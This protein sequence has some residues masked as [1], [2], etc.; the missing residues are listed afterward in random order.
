ML[1]T[2]GPLDHLLEVPV[3]KTATRAAPRARRKYIDEIDRRLHEEL[4]EL[5]AEYRQ[6]AA[7]N[8]V[9][10]ATLRMWLENDEPLDVPETAAMFGITTETLHDWVHE[11]YKAIAEKRPLDHKCFIKHDVRKGAKVRLWHFNRL[12]VY[13]WRNQRIR[14]GTTVATPRTPSGRHRTRGAAQAAEAA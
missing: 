12:L 14:P 11:T 2:V 7:A 5:V 6:I 13:G 4:D 1:R 9:D 3:P 8:G 10:E